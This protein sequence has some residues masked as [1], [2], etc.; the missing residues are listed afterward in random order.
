MDEQ[1]L[2]ILI[3]EL[4]AGQTAQLG[5]IQELTASTDSLKEK[6][7]ELPC[8]KNTSIIKS[9]ADWKKECN[10]NNQSINI[11]KLKGTI[12]LKNGILIIVATAITTGIVTKFVELFSR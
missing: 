6:M 7:N 5:A 8:E 1:Q 11:E 3:G 9:L 2:F 10:G 4:K 12:S